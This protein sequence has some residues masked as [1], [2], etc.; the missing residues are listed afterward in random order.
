[1]KGAENKSG[2]YAYSSGNRFTSKA[3]IMEASHD[4]GEVP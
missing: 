3:A 4:A 2:Y 1:M